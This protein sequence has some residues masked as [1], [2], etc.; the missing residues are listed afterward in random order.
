[1]RLYR[2]NNA[3]VF[4]ICELSVV[5]SSGPV[6]NA[7]VPMTFAWI[8]ASE[9][10]STTKAVASTQSNFDLCYLVHYSTKDAY[11]TGWV[12]HDSSANEER[13]FLSFL[14]T[15]QGDLLVFPPRPVVLAN[16]CSITVPVES[17][18]GTSFSS[19][20]AVPLDV[21]AMPVLCRQ[22]FFDSPLL[23][24]LVSMLPPPASACEWF[25]PRTG[26]YSV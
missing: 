21:Q 1:M 6:M 2:A 18:H 12:S 7:V 25:Y 5:P 24:E 19:S 16:T 10:V 20:F 15:E 23:V 8:T 14:S 13:T 26:D 22:R 11:G 9:G 4:Y 3:F 17:M